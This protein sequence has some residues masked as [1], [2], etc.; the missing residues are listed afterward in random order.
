MTYIYSIPGPV[1]ATIVIAISCGLAT[2]SYG[3]GRIIMIPRTDEQTKDLAGSVIFRISALHSLIL[4]LVFAQELVNFND[5]RNN[6]TREAALVGDI[7]YDLQRY[8]DALTKSAQ[9]DLLDY[10]K[11]V[12]N[13]ERQS[14]AENAELNEQAWEEWKSAY[15]AILDL[16]P[17]N[18]R[19]EA[20]K[21]I[22][23]DRVREIS[24]LRISRENNALSG[25]HNL[26]LIAAVTGIVIISFAYFPFPPTGGNLTLLLVFGLYTGLV[27]YFIFAFANPFSGVEQFESVR[28]ER[29]YEG[30]TRNL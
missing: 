18:A 22:M 23:L 2:G 24:D 13:K 4:A 19:Q 8:D 25:V 21:P 10:T 11:I 12:L 27:I 16:E 30:M 28:F 1:L 14:L 20:L 7:F 9:A 15:I 17:G 6:M 29:L 26:F 3:L 5:A